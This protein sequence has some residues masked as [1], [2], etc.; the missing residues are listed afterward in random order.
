VTATLSEFKKVSR[1]GVV[2]R[3]ASIVRT[4][5]TLE[6]GGLQEVVSVAA[7]GQ[8]NITIESQAIS[9]GLDEQELR[10]LPAQ[11]PRHPGLPHAQPEHCRRFR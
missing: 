5:L 10:D 6:V 7:E 1:S 2:L 3:A 11:Q 4:D 8:N 9:R